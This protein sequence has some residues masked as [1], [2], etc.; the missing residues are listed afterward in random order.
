MF[1]VFCHLGIWCEPVNYGI[2]FKSSCKLSSCCVTDLV[3][4]KV[5]SIEH[6]PYLQLFL[7]MSRSDRAVHAHSGDANARRSAA[8]LGLPGLRRL[9]HRCTVHDTGDCSQTFI[10][11]NVI[12][13]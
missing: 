10:P 3:C 6:A 1:F 8:Q 4:L 7:Y 2:R 5:R 12:F 13:V 9:P 11:E